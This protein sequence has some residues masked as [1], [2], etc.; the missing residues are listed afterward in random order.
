MASRGDSTA[1]PVPYDVGVTHQRSSGILLHPTSLPGPYGIGDLGPAAV[2]WL[3]WLAASGCRSWQTLPL[4][5]TGYGDSPYA[6]FSAFAGNPYLISPDLLAADG[7]V[8]APPPPS[9]PD[10]RV[11]YGAVIPWKLALLDEAFERFRTGAPA[12]LSEEHAAFR[13]RHR[14]W[15]EDYALFMAIKADQGGGP[16]WDWPDPLRT[17]R[18]DALAGEAARLGIEVERQMFRQFL[19]FRQWAGIRE[20]AAARGISI[21]GDIPIFVAPDSVDVWSR[22]DLFHL[23]DDRR[24]TVVAGV[25]PDYFSDT[26][27]LWGN[28]LYDWEAHAAEGYAWWV[29][30][31]RHTIGMVDVV[32]IDHFRG[33]VD[34]WEIPSGAPTAVEG[35]WVEGPGRAVFDAIEEALGALPIIAEDLGELHPGVPALRDELGLPGMK[36]LQF[37][38]DGDP[39]NPFLPEH[40]PE[41]CIVYTGTHDNDTT[42]GWYRTVALPERIRARKAVG[43]WGQ[44]ASIP[45]EM[46]GAAWRS[47][48]GLA[49]APL[50][51]VLG[52]GTAARMNTPATASG[53]WRW[54]CAEGALT[55]RLA[56]RLRRLNERTG[57]A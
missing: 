52:L 39:D 4:G 31:I 35:R 41:N 43:A 20:A 2:A 30:R 28:P 14:G 17:A 25:P 34:Y 18:P 21:I 5:P 23:D 24:M 45:W 56:A 9:L 3:D 26:G 50:Q 44:A 1:R 12:G 29:E 53:N 37:A 46:I 16:W 48:A 32:R 40:Y 42:L 7:L 51:D 47:R 55:P 13:E 49:I 15:L 27:Q 36:I 8:D 10:D 6:C 38:F 33:F 57:R 11:D 22:P 54:R 19:F